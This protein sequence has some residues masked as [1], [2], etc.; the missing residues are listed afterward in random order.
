MH[1]SVSFVLATIIIMMALV[2]IGA[3]TATIGYLRH[4]TTSMPDSCISML[5]VSL[6]RIT[7]V[8]EL[9]FQ[10]VVYPNKSAD[11]LTIAFP[12]PIAVSPSAA[13]F[14]RLYMPQRLGTTTV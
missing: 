4:I 3:H 10:S 8:K 14:A 11:T 2:A 6:R 5:P 13:F 12:S 1:R 7:A 9:V